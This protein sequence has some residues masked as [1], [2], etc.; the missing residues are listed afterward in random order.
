MTASVGAHDARAAAVVL[1]EHLA[2][3]LLDE[4]LERHD[5]RGAAVLVDDDGHLVAAGAQL[6]DE[7]VEVDRLG[8]AQ[9]LGRERGG[10]D[11][12]PALARA[13]RRRP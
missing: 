8:N 3:D 5:T 6:G 10:R 2:D 1:V 12:G 7:R 13:R 9:R 4:V 11:V